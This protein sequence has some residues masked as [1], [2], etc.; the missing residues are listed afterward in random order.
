M[1]CAAGSVACSVTE[2]VDQGAAAGLEFP[3]DYPVKA[4]VRAGDGVRDQV[5]EAIGKHASLSD[6]EAVRVRPSRNGRFESLTVTVQAESRQQLEQ[7][8]GELRGLDV[9][10]MML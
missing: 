5:L 2:S 10:V 9:V 8:Y 1:A 6:A 4:M 7:V 3:C